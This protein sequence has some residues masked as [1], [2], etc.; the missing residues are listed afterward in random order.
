[1][2]YLVNRDGNNQRKGINFSQLVFEEKTIILDQLETKRF[3]KFLREYCQEN[4][5]KDFTIEKDIRD[6]VIRALQNALDWETEAPLSAIGDIEASISCNFPGHAI[7]KALK[8]LNNSSY[9]IEVEASSE[10]VADKNSRQEVY[11]EVE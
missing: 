5:E 9:K 4:S 1:M 10:R 11:E 3:D 8:K 2:E 6:N 7:I